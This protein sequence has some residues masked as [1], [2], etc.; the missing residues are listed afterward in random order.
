M[1]IYK[2]ECKYCKNYTVSRELETLKDF[3]NKECKQKYNLKLKRKKKEAI[4]L[5][6]NK[7]VS[8]IKRKRGDKIPIFVDQ[9]GLD[10]FVVT[11]HN[12]PVLLENMERYINKKNGKEKESNTRFA[13]GR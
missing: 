6:I 1:K 7:K 2:K 8:Q 12:V 9:I 10:T 11:T 5:R 4:K 3:C 13:N